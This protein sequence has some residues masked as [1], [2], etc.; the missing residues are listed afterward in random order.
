MR[1][2]VM[3]VRTW[4]SVVWT[5]AIVS[6]MLMVSVVCNRTAVQ[7]SIAYRNMEKGRQSRHPFNITA[8]RILQIP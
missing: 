3:T 8:N 1:V 7:P 5:G 4:L 6:V 2:P